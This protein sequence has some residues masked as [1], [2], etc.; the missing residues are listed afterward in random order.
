MA[1]ILPLSI[2]DDLVGDVDD[3]ACRINFVTVL[4]FWFL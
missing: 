1:V 4:I 3:V 2:A